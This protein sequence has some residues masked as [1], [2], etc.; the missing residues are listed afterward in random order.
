MKG[1]PKVVA[2]L[3][4]IWRSESHLLTYRNLRLAGFSF[5]VANEC[6]K[7]VDGTIM[8]RSWTTC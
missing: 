4:L 8:F 2:Y 7:V 6:V 1:L 5:L 3:Q